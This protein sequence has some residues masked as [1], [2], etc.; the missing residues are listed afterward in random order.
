MAVNQKTNTH[1]GIRTKNDQIYV[2]F[3]YNG[4]AYPVKNFT[5]LYSCTT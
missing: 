1:R 3:K 4:R 2:R 5:K